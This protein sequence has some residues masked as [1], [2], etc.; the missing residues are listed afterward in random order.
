MPAQR[1]HAFAKVLN[2]KLRSKASP[3]DVSVQRPPDVDNRGVRVE[4]AVASSVPFEKRGCGFMVEENRG[5]GKHA[6]DGLNA[7]RR[8]GLQI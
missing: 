3:S 6:I 4:V 7:V 2:L 1:T 5:I 8:C